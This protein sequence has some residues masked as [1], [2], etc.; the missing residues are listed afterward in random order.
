MKKT[1]GL[2]AIIIIFSIALI[3][4]T[5]N[6]NTTKNYSA[7]PTLFTQTESSTSTVEAAKSTAPPSPKVTDMSIKVDGGLDTPKLN[8]LSNNQIGWGLPMETAGKIPEVPKNTAKLFS[9]YDAFCMADTTK[10]EIYLTFDCGYEN[11]YTTKILDALKQKGAKAIFFVTMS[12]VKGNK[13]IVQRMIDEGHELGNH[14]VTHPNLTTISYE[15]FTKE[16]MNLNKY[17][18][19][20]LGVQMRYLRPP[21]GVYSERTLAATQ[22]LGFKT[23]LWDFAYQD[24]DP[25]NQKGADYAYE[26]VMSHIHNGSILL[27]HAVSSS[28]AGA[29]HR[30]I[31]GL[32]NAGYVISPLNV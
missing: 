3:S 5:N 16:L 7:A 22:M 27:L 19:D 9:K 25:S 31:D 30:I 28:N 15:D 23:I 8:S 13:P 1:I 21:E 26:K 29:M 12:Y 2:S 4:C 18:S 20:N 11:G 6:P 14:T 17:V 32:R 10:K 24:W